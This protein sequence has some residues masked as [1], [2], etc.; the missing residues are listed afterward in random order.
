MPGRRDMDG[1]NCK[2]AALGMEYLR[3]YVFSLPQVRGFLRY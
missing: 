3:R 1:F 2:E